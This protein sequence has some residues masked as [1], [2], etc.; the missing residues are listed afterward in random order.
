MAESGKSV[1]ENSTVQNNFVKANNLSL[2]RRFDS[3]HVSNLNLSETGGRG[4]GDTDSALAGEL[5]ENLW[6]DVWHG[7]FDAKAA[8]TRNTNQSYNGFQVGALPAVYAKKPARM[9]RL[10]SARSTAKVR[11]LQAVASRTATG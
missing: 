8:Y 5:R 3:L 2:F 9:T 11:L 4:P 1:S 6:A 10:R 7:K